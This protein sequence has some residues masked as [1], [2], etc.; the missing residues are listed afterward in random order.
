MS[1]SRYYLCFNLRLISSTQSLFS[2]LNCSG[3]K[4][5][6]LMF[7]SLQLLTIRYLHEHVYNSKQPQNFFEQK[8]NLRAGRVA[9]GLVPPSTQGVI[10]ETQNRVS[11]WASCMEPDSPSAYV[12]ACL[13]K[14]KKRE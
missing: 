14:K 4:S 2:K 5:L 9:S 11:H 12:S 3:L 7:R 6:S 10:L 1:F 8:N 13:L